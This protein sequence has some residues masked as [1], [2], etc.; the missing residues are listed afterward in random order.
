MQ[1]RSTRMLRSS[2]PTSICRRHLGLP[3]GKHRRAPH[4]RLRRS[5]VGRRGTRS[6]RAGPDGR[7]PDDDPDPSLHAETGTAP[8]AL[9]RARSLRGERPLGSR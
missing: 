9:A 7:S 1:A 3:S 4:S 2:I 6:S 8:W 5:R